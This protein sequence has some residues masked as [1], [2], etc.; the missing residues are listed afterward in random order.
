MLGNHQEIAVVF[1]GPGDFDA[2]PSTY[3]GGWPGLGCGG[4]G[5]RPCLPE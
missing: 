1:G 2:V 5:E 4:A 3:T